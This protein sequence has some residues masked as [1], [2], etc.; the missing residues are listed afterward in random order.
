[1]FLEKYNLDV[2]Q[3]QHCTLC[4]CLGVVA[5]F[6]EVDILTHWYIKLKQSAGLHTVFHLVLLFLFVIWQS[7]M[8]ALSSYSKKVPDL[9]HTRS[10]SNLSMGR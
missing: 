7:F 5:Q 6:S 10:N 3:K 4:Y 9:N 2:F 1:M 8:F